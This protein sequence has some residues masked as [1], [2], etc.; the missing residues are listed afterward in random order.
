MKQ[1]FLR[2]Y[3]NYVTAAKMYFD[4]V[5]EQKEAEATYEAALYRHAVAFKE[6]QPLALM[7]AASE[8]TEAKEL[9]RILTKEVD[10]YLRGVKL[11]HG[12]LTK[13]ANKGKSGQITIIL[14]HSYRTGNYIHA[15]LYGDNDQ[16]SKASFTK[17]LQDG[18]GTALIFGDL[19]PGF[20]PY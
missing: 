2:T 13:R 19:L 7:I 18:K 17:H 6:M 1:E 14:P 16:V 9:V 15:P 12:E 3:N 5:F 8:A 11:A 4:K 10:V 20:Y